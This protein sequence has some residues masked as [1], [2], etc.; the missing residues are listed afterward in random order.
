MI[1]THRLAAKRLGKGKGYIY[2]PNDPAG[3]DV[4]CLPD[5][6]KGKTYYTPSGAGEER[7]E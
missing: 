5:E 6:L 3:Y 4:D 1:R 7:E 2:P